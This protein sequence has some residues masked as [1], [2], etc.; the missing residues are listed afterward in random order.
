MSSADWVR[1]VAPHF[2]ACLVL[3]NDR[4]IAAAPI[5]Q[6]AV[7][8]DRVTL[9]GYFASRGWRATVLPAA[10]GTETAPDPGRSD[11]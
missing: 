9:R 6:W 4:C 3:D 8:K 11:R 7:G 5:L 10:S 2:C 1:V